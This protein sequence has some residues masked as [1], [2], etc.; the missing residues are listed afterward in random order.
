[1]AIQQVAKTEFKYLYNNPQIIL[2]SMDFQVWL[3]QQIHPLD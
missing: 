1:M 3:W 2:L